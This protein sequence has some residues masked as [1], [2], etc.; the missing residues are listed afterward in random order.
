[1]GRRSD[2]SAGLVAFRRRSG[3]EVLLAHPGGPFWTK[4]DD[5][6]WTIP[7]GEVEPGVDLLTTAQREFTEETN[8]VATGDFMPLTPVK[9]K[10]G[11]LVHAFAFEADFDLAQFASNSFEI[12]WPPKSGRRKSFP[13]IDRVGYFPLPTAMIKIIA[14]QLPLLRELNERLR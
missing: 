11:K 13:E 1:M 6:A 14:Y 7:K 10:S 3:I 5:G 8:L 2:V 12:E 9:L 4:K